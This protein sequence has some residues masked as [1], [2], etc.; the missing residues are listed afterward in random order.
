MKV[1]LTKP[2]LTQVP[3]MVYVTLPSKFSQYGY[4]ALPVLKMFGQ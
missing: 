4:A 3:G 2:L 1:A